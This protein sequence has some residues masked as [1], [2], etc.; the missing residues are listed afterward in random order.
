[1]ELTTA[2]AGAA[3]RMSDQSVR[4][5]IAAGRLNARKHGIRG[6][7]KINIEDLRSF[8]L[9]FGYPLDEDYLSR[10]ASKESVN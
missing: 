8:A 5:H 3:L 9:Q 7:L 6:L 10:L 2:E 1:M 4:D